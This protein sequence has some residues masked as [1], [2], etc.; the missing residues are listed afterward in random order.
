M[1]DGTIVFASPGPGGMHDIV[2]RAPDGATT[3][4]LGGPED[5]LPD[6]VADGAVLYHRAVTDGIEVR[7]HVAGVP[8]V[9][10][11][12]ITSDAAG[13][14][15]VR[16]AG[17]R[18]SPCVVEEVQGSHARYLRFDPV[19][20]ARGDEIY[21][22]P[23]TG[24]FMRS[25]SLSPDG[26]TLALVDGSS[27]VTMVELDGGAVS[28]HDTGPGTELQSVTWASDGDS[29]LVTAIGGGRHLFNVFR[30]TPDGASR[31]V[32]DSNFRWFWR[33]QESPDGKRVAIQGRDILLDIWLAEGL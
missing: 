24:R 33:A 17:D 22:A 23:L 18:T 4:M 20:G 8:D 5:D 9:R 30:M 28:R 21:R 3:T 6:T 19:T 32:L 26:A 12:T 7:R 2:A 25:M 1:P 16:C 14:N 11:A 13:A 29:V 10:L 27:T 31:N 15:A